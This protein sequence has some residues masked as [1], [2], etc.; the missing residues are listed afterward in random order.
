MKLV[1]LG[2]GNFIA[3]IAIEDESGIR[4][5]G[6]IEEV[7]HL[8][9]IQTKEKLNDVFAMDQDGPG[10]ANHIYAITKTDV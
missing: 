9:T 4:N 10:G 7:R 1:K 3:G 6:T 2:S 8:E 5:I